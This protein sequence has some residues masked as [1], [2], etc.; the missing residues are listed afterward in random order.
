MGKLDG[1]KQSRGIKRYNVMYGVGSVKYLVNEHDGVEK[2]K[3]GS[4]FF[5]I[6]TFKNKLKLKA[7]IKKLEAQG[8]IEGWA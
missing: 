2:H 3:D 8:Y 6:A 4:D 1:G 7:Y 5:G